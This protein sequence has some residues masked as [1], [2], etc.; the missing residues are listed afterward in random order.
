MSPNQP[1]LTHACPHQRPPFFS[2][3]SCVIAGS[4]L[5]A[6]RPRDCS[7]LL[8]STGLLK[9]VSQALR[10]PLQDETQRRAALL[11]GTRDL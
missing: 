6:P 3:D 1:T 9:R 4:T 5:P 2:G 11:P 7:Q 8:I 10:R